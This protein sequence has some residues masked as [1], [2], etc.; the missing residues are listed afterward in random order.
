[1]IACRAAFRAG[2]RISE[3]VTL[4]MWKGTAVRYYP[5]FLDIS[6][7]LCIV[8]GG[9]KVSERKVE[10]LLAC[11]ARVEVVGKDL[12][13]ALEELKKKGTI[14][15]HEEDYR[16]ERIDGAFLVIGATDNDAV[17]ERIAKDARERGILVNIVDDPEWCDF[18]LPSIVEQGDL[19][20][21][22]STGGRSPALAKKMRKE[23]EVAYGPEYAILLEILG[24][25]R[26]RVIAD[27]RPS[28][29][30]RERFEAVVYSEILDHIRAKQWKRVEELIRELTGIE[31]EVGE[32]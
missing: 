28:A 29:E 6:G 21:T 23:L 24:E 27:G 2:V 30:N 14:L 18:I 17:N 20:I 11:G 4:K 7:R 15:H 25:L 3:Q 16:P 5:I 12:T 31:M 19:T 9:G 22:V 32:R 13:S 26:E 8:V 1:M 10:R